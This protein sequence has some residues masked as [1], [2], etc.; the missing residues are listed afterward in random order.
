MKNFA[1]ILIIFMVGY[2]VAPSVM[3]M[4]DNPTEIS[5][6]DEE[7]TKDSKTEL[8]KKTEFLEESNLSNYSLVSVETNSNS[9]GSNQVLIS[10]IPDPISPPPR[11]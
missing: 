1:Y 8:D 7:G 2:I 9:L 10:F 6:I 5:F 11:I 4:V 3:I